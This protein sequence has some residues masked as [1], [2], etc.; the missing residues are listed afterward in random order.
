MKM[1]DPMDALAPMRTIKDEGPAKD[2]RE[3]SVSEAVQE[4]VE[5]RMTKAAEELK[6]KYARGEGGRDA[7]ENGPTGAAYT[8][9]AVA[10]RERRKGIKD[11]E[12][13]EAE[14]K[15]QKEAQREADV[16]YQFA[17]DQGGSEDDEEE[18]PLEEEDSDDELLNELDGDPEVFHYVCPQFGFA[19][20]FLDLLVA[21]LRNM[22]LTQIKAEQMTKMEMMRK[23]H[24]ELTEIVQDEFLPKITAAARCVVHFYHNDF[25]RCKIMDMH[26][27]D[28]ARRHLDTLFLTINAEKAPFF[29]EKLNVRILPTVISFFN[30]I[31]KPDQ[32]QIGFID[33]QPKAGGSEDEWPV[34]ALEEKLGKIGVIDYVAKATEAELE[35]YGLVQ[36]KSIYSSRHNQIRGEDYD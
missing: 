14:A 8:A 12:R 17:A 16:R 23:G 32:R 24:G 31:T 7:S 6:Q 18:E 19:Q 15:A 2:D 9:A 25:H 27:K 3:K 11:A 10:E 26:L 1:V 34:S 29:C 20:M 21:K 4:E 5:N 30:G 36:K 35:R 33:L 28:I 22:R 13:A